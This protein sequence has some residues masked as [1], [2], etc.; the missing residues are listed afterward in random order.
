MLAT[1]EE[2]IAQFDTSRM[3]KFIRDEFGDNLGRATETVVKEIK[4]SL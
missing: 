2:H 4:K 1:I 3:Q